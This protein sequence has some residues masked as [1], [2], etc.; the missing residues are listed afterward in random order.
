MDGIGALSA[1]ARSDTIAV[2]LGKSPAPPP[3]GRGPYDARLGYEQLD[4]LVNRL[5]AR[6]FA[7]DAQARSSGTALALARLGI[8]PIYHGKNQA[9]F[10][11]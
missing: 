2:G 5:S 8:F 10:G 4:A 6:G 9:V 3:S 1:L 7:V 11:S